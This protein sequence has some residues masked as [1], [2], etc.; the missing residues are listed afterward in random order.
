MNC[1]ACNFLSEWTEKTYYMLPALKTCKVQAIDSFKEISLDGKWGLY[2]LCSCQPTVEMAVGS[3][4][5]TFC[6]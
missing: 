6:L 1:L 5:N 3:M 2:R 4:K